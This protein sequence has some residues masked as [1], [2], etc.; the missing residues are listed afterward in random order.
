[1]DMKQLTLEEK[2]AV[3]AQ[4]QAY[5][6]KYPSQTKAVNSLGLSAGTVSTILNGRFGS[7]SDEMFLRVRSLTAP[8]AAEGW[9]ICETA[10]YRELSLLL[11]DAQQN[12]S[13]AWVVGSAGIGKTTAARD[14]ASRRDNV[15]VVSCS[16]EMRRG[17][18]I[19]ELARVIGIRLAQTSLRERLRAVT[20]A[21]R[22]LD[23]PL[24]V[25]D[26]GDKLTDGVFYY[27][28]SIYNALEGRCGI[29]LLST[30]YI[31]RRMSL[32]LSYTRKGYDEI[33]SRIGRRFI[34][35]T[36]ATRHEVRAVCS[37]NGLTAD[38]AIAEVVADARTV[39]TASAN[40]WEKRI[41]R[42]YFDMRRVRRSVHKSKRIAQ[43]NRK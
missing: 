28:I 12:S 42:E 2:Q 13:V 24:L 9:T 26:E 10:A 39:V 1:M 20:D 25:F 34:D 14:Y 8:A 16:E 17:D 36:P 11:S 3:Q 33:F 5:V 31:R 21:L 19:Q 41:A 6:A 40:P 18:F 37:A 27:F 38:S 23:R 30:E 35:L 32:G 22:T 15:F 4:L 7:I 43:I 29:V